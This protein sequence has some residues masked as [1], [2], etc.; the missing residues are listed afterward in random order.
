MIDAN[1]FAGQMLI[2]P[3]P[4]R[5]A[6]KRK[7]TLAFIIHV[8]ACMKSVPRGPWFVGGRIFYLRSASRNWWSW[9]YRVDWH[10]ISHSKCVMLFMNWGIFS[11]MKSLI[12][13]CS[14]LVVQAQRDL[15]GHLMTSLSFLFCTFLGWI[16]YTN[17]CLQRPRPGSSKWCCFAKCQRFCFIL[18]WVHWDMCACGVFD[19]H[20]FFYLPFSF[21]SG[22]ARHALCWCLNR[23]LVRA[24]E[25]RRSL[26]HPARSAYRK[27]ARS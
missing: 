18:S 14:S 1:I 2:K 10:N 8:L 5:K 21:G 11:L 23:V 26:G 16:C 13:N 15:L 24:S 20:Y 7:G 22:Y 25:L 19:C 27:S 3:C 12:L 6:M 17:Q 9:M 4:K